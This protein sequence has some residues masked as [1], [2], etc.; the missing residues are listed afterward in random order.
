MQKL[1]TVGSTFKKTECI[2]CTVDCQANNA[3]LANVQTHS[4]LL[5]NG[6]EI[7]FCLPYVIL[8]FIHIKIS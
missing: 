6:L 2:E 5:Q 8:T 1:F 4:K 3:A 7:S